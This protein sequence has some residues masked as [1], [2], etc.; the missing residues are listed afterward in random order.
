MELEAGSMAALEARARGRV[1]CRNV[2][3]EAMVLALG[4]KRSVAWKEPTWVADICWNEGK[5]TTSH[6]H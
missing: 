5:G 4:K 6:H 2:S 1:A 3:A